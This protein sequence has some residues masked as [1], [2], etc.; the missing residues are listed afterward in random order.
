[1]TASGRKRPLLPALIEAIGG[2]IVVKPHASGH[3]LVAEYGLAGELIASLGMQEIMV[4]GARYA[5]Y[6]SVDLV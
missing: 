3:F 2:R 1:M 6:L 5:N 4:A